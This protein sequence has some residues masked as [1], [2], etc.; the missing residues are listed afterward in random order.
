[1][2]AGSSRQTRTK[3]A[4]APA[5]RHA[6][7]PSA[8]SASLGARIRAERERQSRSLRAFAR[9]LDLSPSMVSQIE[10]GRAM[11]SVGTL[12]A[13]AT[14]LNL[15]LDRLFSE[16]AAANERAEPPDQP[17]ADDLVQRAASRQHLRLESDVKWER[18]T[19]RPDAHVEFVH[20]V[21]E[22]G[23]MSAPEHQ[24]MRHGGHEYG[25]LISGRLGMQVGSQK[26]ELAPGDSI[27][28]NSQLPHRL[29]TIGAERAVAIWFITNRTDDPR[30]VSGT[31]PAKSAKGA[32]KAKAK[33]ATQSTRA[34]R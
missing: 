21:Y 27:S 19:A 13:I 23:A 26:M 25:Y 6:S 22:P 12:F 4:A 24:L 31:P 8:G 33:A 2:E 3:R 32:S 14:E 30:R 5:K 1:M 10:C 15:P 18:L 17:S 29:W 7:A 9:S 28:F 20:V 16:P 34:P 11:P